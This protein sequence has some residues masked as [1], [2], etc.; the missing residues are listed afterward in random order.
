M[1][2]TCQAFNEQQALSQELHNPVV[3][4]G[5]HSHFHM[6]KVK[7]TVQ[8]LKVSKH[9]KHTRCSFLRVN[10]TIRVTYSEISQNRDEEMA[11]PQILITHFE[12]LLHYLMKY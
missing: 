7:W 3:E 10:R 2:D 4:Y 1:M 12:I 5:Y 9:I 8:G 6:R 11:P